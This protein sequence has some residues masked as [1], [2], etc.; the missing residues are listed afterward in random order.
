MFGYL[1]TILLCE[2]SV[3]CYQEKNLGNVVS[4]ERESLL[5]LGDLA[6]YKTVD[7]YQSHNLNHRQT[8]DT[9][10]LRWNFC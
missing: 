3:S 9:D 10:E 4:L 6:V 7:V 2:L 5:V 8:L 1:I